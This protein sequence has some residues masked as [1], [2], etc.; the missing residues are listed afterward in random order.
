MRRPV[1]GNTRFSQP[2]SAAL[3]GFI[4]LST[5]LCSPGACVTVYVE[6]HGEHRTWAEP[7]RAGSPT[8]PS[9]S[10]LS[11]PDSPTR[12]TLASA[13][14][15][16]MGGVGA[17]IP[18]PSW[19]PELSRCWDPEGGL[20]HVAQSVREKACRR[21]G[22]PGAQTARRFPPMRLRPCPIRTSP[23]PGYHDG[24]HASTPL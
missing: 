19:G 5:V 7:G 23:L 12:L 22:T 18:V 6:W 4:S 24:R 20:Q 10:G 17:G 21:L 9:G 8:L 15:V 14:T 13:W 11:D 3:S 1:T 2:T 16:D